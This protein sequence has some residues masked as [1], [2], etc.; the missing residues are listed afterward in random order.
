MNL[1][2]SMINGNDLSRFCFLKLYIMPL[3]GIDMLVL[4]LNCLV[5]FFLHARTR[6]CC[7]NWPAAWCC[8]FWHPLSVPAVSL[9]FCLEHG[10]SGKHC[11]CL[12]LKLV[13]LDTSHN[14][15]CMVIDEGG[16][17]MNWG[18]AG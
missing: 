11:R 4:S 6:I 10:N 5:L 8:R 2:M 16:S 15:A 14:Y 18:L 1:G 12:T 9:N 7:S 13:S 17:L 3:K